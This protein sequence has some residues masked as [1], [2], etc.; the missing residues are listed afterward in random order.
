VLRLLRGATR[1]F[2]RL[3]LLALALWA[4]RAMLKRYV[5]G[6]SPVASSD[7]WDSG[8]TSTRLPAKRAAAAKKAAPAAKKAEPAAKKAAPPKR[9]ER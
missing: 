2:L 4:I 8:P 3:G 1:A 7:G 6:P 5:Q 9:W